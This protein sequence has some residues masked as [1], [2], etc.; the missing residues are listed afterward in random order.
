MGAEVDLFLSTIDSHAYN[1]ISSNNKDNINQPLIEEN[2]PKLPLLKPKPLK[3]VNSSN[4]VNLLLE[5]VSRRAWSDVIKLSDELLFSS[6]SIYQPLCSFLMNGS[7]NIIGSNQENI[8]NSEEDSELQK[9]LITIIQWRIRSMFHLRRFA[10]MKLCI[11]K[12]NLTF[13]KYSSNELPA[14]IPLGI[15]LQSM[16]CLVSYNT[17]LKNKRTRGGDDEDDDDILEEEKERNDDEILDEFYILRDTLVQ[18]N[19]ERGQDGTNR[20]NDLLELD[21]ILSN[22]LIQNSQWRLALVTLD[23]II[24]YSD[25]VA[26][27]WAKQ[28]LIRDESVNA[29]NTTGLLRNTTHVIAKAITIE[30]YSR[31]GRVL[32]QAG[33]LPAAATIFERAHDEYQELEN[34]RIVAKAIGTDDESN[35]SLANIPREGHAL[36]EQ[37]IVMDIPTQIFINEGLLHFAHMDYDLAEIK[38]SKAIQIQRQM[39]EKRVDIG[40][41]G[42]SNQIVNSVMETEGNLLVPC[43]NN[44]ALCALY[45]CR[46]RDAVALMESLIKE[47]PT[48][49]LNHSIVFNLCTL[50]EL[51]WDNATSDRKKRVLQLVAKR[52]SLHDIGPE[53]FRLA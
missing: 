19:N 50:Y 31:Q 42:K 29:S 46:M 3:F 26:P 48:S 14:W 28:L 2:P 53:S 5:L 40:F 8:S 18:V 43:L 33:A 6:G 30:I 11:E 22:I 44:F 16:E 38:F 20:W 23:E 51:G 24:G 1:L 13:T 15:I 34:S 12:M 4:R 45:T 21:I 37:H 10:D 47:D 52:F 9:D 27:Y 25:N 17:H 36:C 39:Q 35:C 32:L 49:Y 41:M 7:D